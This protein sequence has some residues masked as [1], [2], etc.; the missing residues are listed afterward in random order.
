MKLV[1]AF[2]AMALGTGA[3][4]GIGDATAASRSQIQQARAYIKKHGAD[5]NRVKVNILLAQIDVL[6]VSK[7]GTQANLTKLAITAQ[8][9]H[10]NLDDIRNNF[11]ES[12]SGAFG[13]AEVMVFA[14]A[15]D[16]KNSMGALVA[17]AG[18]PNAATLAHFLTQYKEGRREWN[19]GVR[20]IWRMAHKSKP[21]TV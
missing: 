16:L 17:W 2:A 14:G 21:P 3:L 5:A 7:S 19:S 12:S 1:S 15:N 20:A 18:S 6:R 4:I 9:A 10:D 13:D 11:A 8:Q